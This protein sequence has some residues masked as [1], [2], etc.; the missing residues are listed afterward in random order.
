M[1]I[2]L[3]GRSHVNRLL[4]ADFP[5]QDPSREEPHLRWLLVYHLQTSDFPIA[6]LTKLPAL[7]KAHDWHQCQIRAGV[8]SFYRR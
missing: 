5:T 2:R 4:T 3:E 8:F 6:G 7:H 1:L